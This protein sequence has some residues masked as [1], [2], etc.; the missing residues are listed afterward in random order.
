M[1]LGYRAVPLRVYGGTSTGV[2]TVVSWGAWSPAE[3]DVVGPVRVGRGERRP[4]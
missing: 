3:G 4:G 2:R 1:T